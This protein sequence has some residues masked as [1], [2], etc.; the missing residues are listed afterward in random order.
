MVQIIEVPEFGRVE[1]PDDMTDE[2][3][4]SAIQQ[5]MGGSVPPEGTEASLAPPTIDGQPGAPQGGIQGAQGAV[6][7]GRIT[8]RPLTAQEQAFALEKKPEKAPSDFPIGA[9]IGGT[10]GAAVGAPG[11]PAT[12]IPLAGLGAAGGEAVEQLVRRGF[13]LS[14]VP[15]T[16]LEAGKEIIKE[17][18]LGLVGEGVGRLA[19]KTG[20]AVFRF[21]KPRPIVEEEA[22]R[23][24]R[25]L[26]EN[27]PVQERGRF[28]PFRYLVGPQRQAK[29]TLLPA[30]A[31]EGRILDFAHNASESSILGGQAISD[32]KKKRTKALVNIA[33]D[34]VDSMGDRAEPDL[35]GEMFVSAANKEFKTSRVGAKIMLNTAEDLA[36][37]TRVPIADVKGFAE[38]LSKIAAELKG[39]G[40]AEAGDPII[41][42]ILELEEDLSLTAAKELRSRLINIADTFSA[43]TPKAKVIGRAN[44]LVG[45]VDASIEKALKADG[46]TEALRIWREGTR[47][48]KKSSDE[49]D[50]A[51]IRRLTSLVIKKG[52][53]E[54]IPRAILKGK[55]V[56]N[57]KNAKLASGGLHSDTWRQ[58]QSFFTQDLY[59]RSVKRGTNE[60]VGTS[61]TANLSKM[62]K[63]A[64][65]EI[66]TPGQLNRIQEFANALTVIQAK[67]AEGSG[68]MFIQLS[69][70]GAVV[71]VPFGQGVNKTAATILLAPGVLAKAFTN[72]KIADILINGIKAGTKTKVAAGAM[73]RF[74][75]DLTNLQFSEGEQ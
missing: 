19:L 25:F 40:G 24:I 72:P 28:N 34:I 51:F 74:V 73:G 64:L 49:F 30:E 16:G 18:G 60:L 46:Q 3:I 43:T 9:T 10:I 31:T 35:L 67:Q 6:P 32:F 62:G 23:A 55:A 65:R 21:I 29:L 56:S 39:L 66:Y 7:P 4:V 54:A 45:L 44:K 37:S 61:L 69:Q 50:N 52:E 57:I 17:G 48:W 33:D 38:P 11:G 71:S 59:E 22:Q 13:G 14:G 36:R 53:P 8:T 1:F 68:R 63:K 15:E 70:A 58:M 41:K 5:N 27:L 47:L 75:T 2:Q 26:N 20:G 42:G 12:A